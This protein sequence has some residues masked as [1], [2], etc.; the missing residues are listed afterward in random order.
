[1]DVSDLIFGLVIGLF[2][3]YLEELDNKPPKYYN[4]PTYCGIV[5]EH[6]GVI[7]EEK[8]TDKQ[9]PLP[10]DKWLAYDDEPADAPDYGGVRSSQ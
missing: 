5:H 6:I 8:E 10:D 2:F 7:H 1:M 4:C 3:G 9:G